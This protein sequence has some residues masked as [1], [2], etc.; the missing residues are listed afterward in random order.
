ML[1]ALLDVRIALGRDVSKCVR[2]TNAEFFF[3]FNYILIWPQWVLVGG[4]QA[5][6]CSMWDLVPKPEIEPGRLNW[7]H[8][9]LAMGMTREVTRF[10]FFN[11]LKGSAQVASYF[12]RP[13]MLYGFII[14]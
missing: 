13:T 2:V 5:L 14:L 1:A 10:F 7:E 12:M 9:V 3:F 11:E 8:R 6:S 4:M